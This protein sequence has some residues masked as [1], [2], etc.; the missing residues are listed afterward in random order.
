[1]V[2]ESGDRQGCT[3]TNVPRHGKSLYFRPISTMGTRTLGVR[4][5]LSLE[6]SCDRSFGEGGNLFLGGRGSFSSPKSALQIDDLW[7]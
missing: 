3:P 6:G 1:M 4:P 2:L 7:G 5:S